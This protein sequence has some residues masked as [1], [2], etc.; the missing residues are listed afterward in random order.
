VHLNSA[1]GSSHI[2]NP[3]YQGWPTKDKFHSFVEHIAALL[4]VIPLGNHSSFTNSKFENKLNKVLSNAS[5]HSLYKIK[6][7]KKG[8]REAFPLI[9]SAILREIS[10]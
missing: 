10:M 5:N 4:K 1:F 8:R 9:V 7:F 2:A 3:A 6:L